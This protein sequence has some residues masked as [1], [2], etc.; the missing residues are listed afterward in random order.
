MKTEYVPPTEIERQR[1]AWFAERAKSSMTM[2][3]FW[4]LNEEAL[5]L[6]PRTDEERQRKTECLMAMPEF[7]L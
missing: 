2:D 7:A 1:S 5:Q 4:R 3:E 6:F